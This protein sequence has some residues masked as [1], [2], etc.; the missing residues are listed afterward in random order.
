MWYSDD[1]TIEKDKPIFARS[2]SDNSLLILLPQIKEQYE[3]IGYNW[4][5]IHTG[6]YNSSAFFSTVEVAFKCYSNY[7][8]F[9]G[10]LKID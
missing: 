8:I 2:K 9:N 6:K 10:I 3:I 5:N 4:F 7:T 1:K